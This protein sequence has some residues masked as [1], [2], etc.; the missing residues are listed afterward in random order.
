MSQREVARIVKVSEWTVS[1]WCK[2]PDFQEK[3]M[4]ANMADIHELRATRNRLIREAQLIVEEELANKESPRRVEIARE[5]V[6]S[7][8]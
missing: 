4:E 8:L 6:R 2:L 5:V 1:M 3:V 7:V